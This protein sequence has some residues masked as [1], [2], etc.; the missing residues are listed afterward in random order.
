KKQIKRI[1]FLILPTLKESSCRLFILCRQ[2]LGLPTFFFSFR[3]ELLIVLPQYINKY[4]ELSCHSCYPDF[5]CGF[6]LYES[7]I[8]PAQ[9]FIVPGGTECR[10]VQCITYK[11]VPLLGYL[12]FSFFCPGLVKLYI[13]SGI[14]D[15]LFGIPDQCK[16]IGF[17]EDTYYRH[18]AGPG[19]GQHLC[20][21]VIQGLV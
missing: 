7:F 19:K 13:Q 14:A 11:F 16:C 21:P 3:P 17:R 18:K 5:F 12:C 20:D 1:F 9:L 10:H 6:S 8:E 4:K 15:Q 2:A